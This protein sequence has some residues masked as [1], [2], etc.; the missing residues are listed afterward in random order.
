[1]DGRTLQDGEFVLIPGTGSS[2][3]NRGE[4]EVS[5]PE[6]RQDAQF[7]LGRQSPVADARCF[8]YPQPYWRIAWDRPESQTRLSQEMCDILLKAYWRRE[9]VSCLSSCDSK[10]VTVQKLKTDQ[11]DAEVRLEAICVVVRTSTPTEETQPPG[12]QSLKR[13]AEGVKD[14]LSECGGRLSQL[15]SCS[16]GR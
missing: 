9:Q 1:M 2:P 11:A 3:W 15:A 14:V 5:E 7:D 4:A 16:R 10:S 8:D 12:A 6:R 13:R